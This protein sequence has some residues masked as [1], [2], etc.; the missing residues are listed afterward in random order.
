MPEVASVH[1]A[2]VPATLTLV[3]ASAMIA[4]VALHREKA[5]YHWLLLGLL[6]GLLLW[7]TGLLLRWSVTSVA[8]LGAALNL[9][10]AGILATPPFWLLVAACHARVRVFMER[11]SAS[12]AIFVPPALAYLALLTNDGHRLFVTETSFAALEA[13]PPAYAGPVFW[14][15]LVYSYVCTVVGVA[16]YVNDAAR[17]VAG[18]DRH[19]GI[20]LAVG[21]CVPLLSSLLYVFQIA[22]IPF[23]LTP[24]GL[25]VTMVLLY[26]AVFRYRLLES[27]PLA[28]R[29]MIRHLEDGVVMATPSGTIVD[30]NPAAERILGR[31]A[32]R[33]REGS[34][35]EALLTLAHPI[36]RPA[37][38][39]TLA[40]GRDLSI[41]LRTLEERRIEV[42]GGHVCEGAGEPVGQFVLLHDRTDEHRYER[43]ARQTQ[44]LETVGTLAAGIAHEVNSPLAFVRANLFQIVRLGQMVDPEAEGPDRKLAEALVDLRPLAEEALDGVDRIA[45]IVS[46]MRH[47]AAGRE[48]AFAELDLS[49]VADDALRLACLGPDSVPVVDAYLAPELPP[50]T[51]SPQRLVQ[52][53]L[54]LL[55]NAR[56]AVEGLDGGRIA[57]ETRCDEGFVALE[58]EDNGPGVP[59]EVRERIFDPFFTTRDPDV[60]MG[61]GLSIAF[62]IARE[63]GGVLEECSH[64]GAGARFALR[65]PRRC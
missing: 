8:G 25:T 39:A 61:L 5:L 23:D 10:Y 33:V 4:H 48:E 50:V 18:E 3:A 6:S 19:R 54:N 53:V 17:L 9:V 12:V 51:G 44:K 20:L 22:P 29:D 16:F 31:V 37:L 45:G 41:E 47:L 55:V 42:S 24:M 30:L 14:A 43:I 59:P 58:V 49:R 65:L 11:P 57:V 34:L 7:T 56:Q 40:R 15:M 2:V 26:V 64:P 13:G 28:R 27:V 21:A 36:E 52:V 62:D 38:A 60:G 63:H 1:P 46:D 32:S 35:D